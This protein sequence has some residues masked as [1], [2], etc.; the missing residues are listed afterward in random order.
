MPLPGASCERL[1]LEELRAIA[2]NA[3][4]DLVER[5]H[6]QTAGI[7][8]CLQHQRR[9]RADQHGLGDTLGAMAANIAGDFA[10]AHGVTDMDRVFIDKKSTPG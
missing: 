5:F 4:A 10:A 8:R 9:H 3:G 1:R 6:R 2:E 7:G